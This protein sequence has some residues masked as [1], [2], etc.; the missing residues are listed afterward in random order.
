VWCGFHKLRHGFMSKELGF[1]T[2]R[3]NGKSYIHW[4]CKK[5]GDVL[6]TMELTDAGANQELDDKH[7][8]SSGSDTSDQP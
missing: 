4:Y 5:T 7:Q 2:E 6:D 1:Q 3:H 8:Q